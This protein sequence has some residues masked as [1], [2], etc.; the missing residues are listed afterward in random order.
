MPAH[1]PTRTALAV[2]AAILLTVVINLVLR[3]HANAVD[4]GARTEPMPVPVTTYRLQDSYLSERRF[5]GLV[6]A[7]QRTDLGFESAGE[8]ASVAVNEGATVAAGDLLAT[9]DDR[10]LR[11]EREALAAEMDTLD[12]DLELARLKARRLEELQATGAASRDAHDETRLR[13]AALTSQRRAVAARLKRLDIELEKSRLRAPYD[14]VVAARHL[15][16]GAIVAPGA[17]VLRLVQS[18]QR[19]AHVGVA[20]ALAG[21]LEPGRRYRLS[22]RDR[23]LEA[24]LRAVRPDVDPT[25]RAASAVFTLPSGG[26]ALDGEA[27]SLALPNRVPSAGGWLPLSALLEG[28]RGIWNVLAVEPREGGHATV[29]QVV[30]V[31][32]VHGDRAYVRGTLTDGQTVVADG[33]HRIAAGAPVTPLEP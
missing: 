11:A 18:G 21:G 8:L 30:E 32:E 4:H 10:R 14:G 12:A 13:A 33:L 7:G 16:P 24:I 20:P 6:E 2:F 3:W 31:L 25:T 26:T 29:R 22:W 19:E 1:A 23:E 28:E 9:L 5:L 15:D 27:V 17:P